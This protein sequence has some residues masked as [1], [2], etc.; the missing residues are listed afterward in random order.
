MGSKK[1]D[2]VDRESGKKI[3]ALRR[4]EKTRVDE[5]EKRDWLQGWPPQGV[6]QDCKK[7]LVLIGPFYVGSVVKLSE[8]V[9]VTLANCKALQFI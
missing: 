2:A 1:N 7:P 5:Q 8:I 4:E 9:N 3:N 6:C